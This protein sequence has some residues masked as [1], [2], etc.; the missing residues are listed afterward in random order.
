V[1]A[2]ALQRAAWRHP[3]AAAGG[4][5]VVAW[6]LLLVAA[7]AAPQP[8]A[9]HHVAGTHE[10]WAGIAGGWLLMTVAMMVPGALLACRHLALGALW[11]RRQRT[12][13]L[14]LGAYLGVWAVFGAAV[15]SS[16]RL[17][18]VTGAA[19][20]PAALAAGAVWQ[21]TPW[22][23]RAVRACHL[24]PQLPPR[25]TR[26]DAACAVAGATYGRRCLLACWPP[27]LGMAVAGHGSV[28]LM[29]LL[30]ALVSAEKLAARP[31]RLAVPG[32]VALA[33]AAVT[34]LL[35]GAVTA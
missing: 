30:T 34:S 26:A 13:V 8:H 33:A 10:G 6:V 7:A 21:L 3:E 14:F 12:I 22:K 18:G 2:P 25:G 1:T 20:L 5:A 35:L 32:A 23:W 29:G 24:L 31:G 17:L 9:G 19:V 28:V 27:M 4:V 15:W 11:S 16:G